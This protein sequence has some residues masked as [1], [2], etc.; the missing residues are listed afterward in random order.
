M[1]SQYSAEP[2][3][4]SLDSELGSFLDRQLNLIAI[5]IQASTNSAFATTMTEPPDADTPLIPGAFMNVNQ[6]QGLGMDYTKNGLWGCMYNASGDLEW[7]RYAP[8]T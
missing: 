4:G 7:K 6:P 1:S 3:P 8:T 5:A 2:V